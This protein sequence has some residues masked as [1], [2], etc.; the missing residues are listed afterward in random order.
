MPRHGKGQKV[1]TATGQQYGQAQAQEQAQQ[2]IPLP[3]MNRPAPSRMAPG[4]A[5]FA[6]PTERPNESIMAAGSPVETT[7]AVSPQRR[8]D[9][10]RALIALEPMASVP[11][12]S[13]HLRN[14][15]RRLQAFV[16]D[17]DDF[18]EMNPLN[19]QG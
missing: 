5:A 1:Q 2:A 13:P 7:D 18:A 11:G 15:V 12:A 6:R 17:V 8:F 16:G 9:A 19:G 14:T 10:M 4:Q 3:K